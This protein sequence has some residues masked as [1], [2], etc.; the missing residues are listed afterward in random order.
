MPL[1]PDPYTKNL[2]LKKAME[3]SF[4]P[5][6]W[7]AL[8]ETTDPKVWK[9]Y[10][11]KALRSYV[12]AAKNSI[13]IHDH[14]WIAEFEENSMRCQEQIKKCKSF[15]EAL[16]QFSAGIMRQSYL[17]IGLI[18]RHRGKHQ[19]TLRATDWKLNNFRTVQYVQSEEQRANIF[20]SKLQKE[21]GFQ[22]EIDLY[23]EYRG[24]GS[25][26]SFEDWYI[27]KTPNL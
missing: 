19:V 4:G 1:E 12:V 7:Y 24:S 17:Q 20:W 15:D 26:D 11:I 25:K 14:E 5:D 8:K 9:K 18:P 22:A 2:A 3:E 6:A 23:A 27:K 13:T 21:I 16:G 10:F